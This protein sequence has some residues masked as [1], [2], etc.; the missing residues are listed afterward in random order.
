MLTELVLPAPAK[1]NLFLHITGRRPDGYHNLQTLFQFLDFGDQLTMANSDAGI[2][3]VTNLEGVEPEENLIVKAARLLQQETGCQQGAKIFLDKQLPIGGGLGGGSSNAATTLLGLNALWGLN[4]TIDHLAALGLRLG[5]DVP[6]FVRGH[7][8]FAEGVGEI[9]TP[10]ELRESWFL[11]VVPN[12]QVNTATM[13][14]HSDLTR[15]SLPIRVRDVLDREGVALDQAP[16]NNQEHLRKQQWRNDFE[17]LVRSLYPEVDKTLS[18]LD[19]LADSSIGRAMMS[20]SG[21]SIFARFASREQALTAQAELTLG[22]T[23]TKSTDD[24]SRLRSFVARGVNRSPL[25][26]DLQLADV[27]Y[28]A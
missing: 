7:S 5:A 28:G 24:T 10:V 14:G 3:L 11:V 4:L 8:A 22:V 2:E 17:P 6:V 16:D 26:T 27:M 9:L 1:L 19:N 25:H 20:G 23:R 21:A 15:D 18:L 12:A 13:Y